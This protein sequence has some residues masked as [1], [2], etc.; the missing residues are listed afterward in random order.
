MC[1]K[2]FFQKYFGTLHEK[3]YVIKTNAFKL[4]FCNSNSGRFLPYLNK[5]KYFESKLLCHSFG[6]INIP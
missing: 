1:H 5:V 2:L 3:E 6:K 4:E